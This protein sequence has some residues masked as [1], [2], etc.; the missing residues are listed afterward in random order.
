[1]E[2][3]PTK[4]HDNMSGIVMGARTGVPDQRGGQHGLF[5]NGVP[6]GSASLERAWIYGLKQ[7]E[8]NRSN[9]A[10]VNTGEIDASSSSFEIT[11]YD[12]SGD[13]QASSRSVRLG[14][15]CRMQEN[16][17]LG[18]FSQGYVHVR[19]TSGNTPFI[20]YGVVNDGGAPG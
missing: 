20:A 4:A 7:N 2:D 8:E 14:P 3:E 15:R 11:I 19:K 10:L 12:G 17:I 6:Y 9:L 16:G 18:N 5:Y 1:M 13:S